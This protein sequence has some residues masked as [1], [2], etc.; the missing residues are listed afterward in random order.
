[1]GIG[2][3]CVG[4]GNGS[5]GGKTSLPVNVGVKNSSRPEASYPSGVVGASGYCGR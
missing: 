4:R 1:M 3:P 2:L 5:S